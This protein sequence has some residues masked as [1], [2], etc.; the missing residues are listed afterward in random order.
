MAA[1]FPIFDNHIHLRPEFQ[2][3]L[4]AKAFEKAGGT[5]FLLT[6][7]PYD[8]IP[9][10]R[11]ED[12]GPAYE[13]TIRMAEAVRAATGVQVFVALGPYPVD[14]LNLRETIGSAAA[15]DAI[16]KGID[17]AAA[18][19]AGERAVAF[20]EIGRPHFPVDAEIVTACNELLGYAMARAKEL[21]CAVVLHTEDPT[22]ETFAGLARI[23][24]NARLDPK[25]VVKHHS[26]PLTR[27]EDTHGLV[28]S[29]LAKEDLG[30]EALKVATSGSNRCMFRW[31]TFLPR[32]PPR[33]CRRAYSGRIRQAPVRPLCPHSWP[34][35]R[36]LGRAPGRRRPRGPSSRREI[37]EP[38]KNFI[39]RTPAIASS[40]S[41][42]SMKRNRVQDLPVS[43]YMSTD[44]VTA[45]PDDTLG[46]VLGKMKSNDVHEL[47]V[48]ERKKL[49][50]VV[51]MRELMRRRNLP[52]TT[53]VST[54]L[55][56]APEI[57]PDT[58]LPEAA[59]KM[60]SAGFR[61]V[62]VVKGKSLI[63]IVSR[64]DIVRALVDTRAVEGLSVREFM[65]PNPQCV[66]EDD[67]VEH[68]VQIMR[69]LGERSVPVVDKNRHLKGV[70]GLKDVVE[71]FARPKVREHYGE[72][73][74]REAKVGL[75]VKG[76]MRYPPYT[77]GPDADVQ[78][79]AELMAKNHISS[80]IVAERDEPVGII[81]NQDLMQFLAGLRERQ[82]LFVEIGGLEDDPKDTYDEIYDIVQKEMRRI[83]PLVEPRTLAIHLQKYKPEGDRWK[84]SLRARFTTAHRIYYAHHFDWDLHV[85]LTGLLETLYKRIVKEK[86][87]K[88]TERK[89]HHSA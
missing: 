8:D 44:L 75:E 15:V 7:A 80:I 2:G 67:T 27:T 23:A 19:I 39:I 83:A 43:A 77:V 5:A 76:V 84:Y 57:N 45:T 17:L 40:P 38:G 86:E 81:T 88:V 66:A 56:I 65:T 46:D 11:G 60:I 58:A 12:Y 52:P 6:H 21:D 48:L 71:L 36:R 14:L 85:A 31:A 64:S 82:Q 37:D 79:A 51:T 9:I 78:R 3:V 49:A 63:G 68:A 55:E 59:E 87:R 28:P 18:H 26:T 1:R 69:S 74:G 50:G 10:H 54:V 53:K 20:G 4:A 13:K 89:R 24:A 35:S 61:A 29:I 73:A 72:R 32:T 16:R 42:F 33:H 34:G 70:V 22:R 47:P 25:R 62:P 30:V 41:G